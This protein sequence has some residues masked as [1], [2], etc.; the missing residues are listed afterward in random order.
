VSCSPLPAQKPEL[1]PRFIFM[2]NRSRARI[3]ITVDGSLS[4]TRGGWGIVIA[5]DEREWISFGTCKVR[6]TDGVE[7]AAALAGLQLADRLGVLR[8]NRPVDLVSDSERLVRACRDRKIRIYCA[9]DWKRLQS[10][11]HVLT[12]DC[13]AARSEILSFTREVSLSFVWVKRGSVPQHVKADALAR[14]ALGKA[15]DNG[16][17]ESGLTRE[18]ASRSSSTPQDHPFDEQISVAR[19]YSSCPGEAA[20]FTRLLRRG[21][22]SPP[23]RLRMGDAVRSPARSNWATKPITPRLPFDAGP[24][25]PILMTDRLGLRVVDQRTRT[26]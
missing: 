15:S 5:D 24:K 17:H 26:S 21:R 12:S 19:L 18:Q 20:V 23:N 22:P 9:T 2:S 6:S 8:Q 25:C 1:N 10:G 11:Y 4:R 7:F 14:I 3:R 16:L 13:L